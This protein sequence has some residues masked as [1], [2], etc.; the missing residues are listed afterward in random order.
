MKRL[1]TNIKRYWMFFAIGVVA[2]LSAIGLDI[3]NPLLQRT[4]VDDVI[5]GGNRDALIPALA[6][7]AGITLGRAVLG[8][9]KEYMFD[10]GAVNTVRDMRKQLFDHIQSLSFSFFDN[11]NTG[12][13]MSR[14][15]EDMENVWFSTAFG[16]MLLIEQTISFIAGTVM[17][18]YLNWKL[19]L[20]SLITMP[21]IALIGF[22]LDKKMGE[23]FGKISD[24]SAVLNTTAQENL[25]GVRLVK[26]FGREKYEIK[27]FLEHNKK[28]YELNQEQAALWSRYFPP[29]ELF[30]NLALV[31][32]AGVGGLF[33]IR[34]EIT[35]GTL[36]AFS[37]YIFFLIWPM[38]MLAWIIGIVARST[39]SLKKI[40]ELF[41][42]KPEIKNCEKPIS[43][44]KINGHVVF[45]NVGFKY[46]DSQ[47][48]KDINIE[49]K[50]G[51]TIAL[52]GTTGAGKSSVIN[53]LSRFYDC[54]EGKITIDGIDI[55]NMEINKLRSSI[56]VVMQETFLFSDAINEN[57]KFGL[58]EMSDE[59]MKEGAE[60]AQAHE[61]ISEL[62][63]GYETVIGERGIGLSGGQ[64]QRLTIARA[65]A[66]NCPIL[67]LDDSTSALDM[68]TEYRI[69]KAVGEKQGITK[70]IIAHR[71]SAV[72]NADEILIIDD[73]KIVERGSHE[74]LLELGGKYYETYCEQFGILEEEKEVG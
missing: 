2:M 48:L 46:N 52:M 40:D 11:I 15:K 22:M 56:G 36:V 9:V 60:I 53:L 70:F 33:V 4:I 63:E 1:L 19:A 68:E 31:L 17:V 64:K 39:A 49:A 29:I 8:Y 45:E 62:S 10:I 23:I 30:T 58:T 5:K 54:K 3:F 24:H 41:D 69:Q 47:I 73:G 16:Q 38:R 74:D 32:V 25:A 20:I 34:E 21:I 13:L 67:I 28:F 26:A 42:K 37:N 66:R 27:K 59:I 51:Q 14:I 12:E 61:F 43:P 50:P 6:G 44:E 71:I 72:K 18:F 57:I 7:L 55:K 65:I 35:I